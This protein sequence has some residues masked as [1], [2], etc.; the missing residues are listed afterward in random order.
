[1]RNFKLVAI[2]LSVLFVISCAGLQRA[3]TPIEKYAQALGIWVDSTTQFKFY[4]EKVDEA[5]KAKW[6][7]E[8]RPTLIKAKEILDLWKVHVF[9]GETTT[10]EMAQWKILKNELLYY[11]ATQM[12]GG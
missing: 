4:Y 10:D 5:T 11:I 9:A 2:F 3:E 12:E 6:D 1:M 8:Y 7:K